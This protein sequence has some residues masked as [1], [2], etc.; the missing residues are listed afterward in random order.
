MVVQRH[1][2]QSTLAILILWGVALGSQGRKQAPKMPD[3]PPPGVTVVPAGCPLSEQIAADQAQ[4]HESGPAKRGS[5]FQ[6]LSPQKLFSCLSPS[7]MVVESLDAK[8]SVIAFG[9][10]V[11][12]GSDHVIT[13]R[14]VIEEGV[15]FR[16]EH[17]GKGWPAKLIRV[18]PDHDLAEL[19]VPELPDTAQPVV[20]R[21]SSTL[22]VGEKVYAIGAP[23]GLELTISEGLVSGLRDLD[24]D[25]IIQTS[26]A[27]S[28][29]SSGGG[30]FDAQGRL[31]GI[32]TFYL[33][34]GQ[35]LNF[36][37]PAEWAESLDDQPVKATASSNES[38]PA[39][40][41]LVWFQVGWT[42]AMAGKYAESVSAFKEAL[43]LRP[44]GKTWL[45]LGADYGFLGQH[46]KAIN[47]Y[48]EA[49]RLN[50]DSWAA[51]SNLGGEYDAL[52]QNDK[53][54]DAYQKT[55]RLN[56]NLADAWVQLGNAYTHIGKNLQAVGALQEAVRLKPKEAYPW[57]LIGNVYGALGQYDKAIN[58]TQNAVRLKPDDAAAWCNLGVSYGKLGFY[59]KAISAIQES[60]RLEPDG[61]NAWFN[62]GFDYLCMGQYEKAVPALEKALK[63]KPDDAIAWAELGLAYAYLRQ[64]ERAI[65]A[66][67][68]AVRLKPDYAVAWYDLG[69]S[70]KA[71]GQRSEVIECYQKLKALNPELAEK[72]FQTA[73]LP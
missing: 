65:S 9:S 54:V 43:R 20:K 14:H 47:A 46:N 23:E 37:L 68:E 52:G 12:I 10:G 21:D 24:K 6:T 49:L 60:L 41:A 17:G 39:F 18:D 29:G 67:Q 48:R 4:S 13:N 63:L 27:I 40:Q 58:A 38:S 8:G 1:I 7:V 64:Y 50:P 31:V 59:E 2:L 69:L 71:E 5:V 28:P 30:L 70:Y 33:K 3:S 62:L 35:S 36:A 57:L 19:S 72:L 26:A 15:S 32:T 34:E 66:N 25:R 11:V 61:E 56:P 22:A 44:D 16:V 51:W 42:T 53:A 55:V 73:V 45:A